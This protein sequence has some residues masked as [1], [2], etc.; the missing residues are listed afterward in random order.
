[1]NEHFVTSN[2]SIE[3]TSTTRS[4]SFDIIESLMRKAESSGVSTTSA[5]RALEG[6]IDGNCIDDAEIVQIATV[7]FSGWQVGHADK[8]PFG[9][10]LASLLDHFETNEHCMQV[11]GEAGKA[12]KVDLACIILG[13][14]ASRAPWA[15]KSRLNACLLSDSFERLQPT[16]ICGNGDPVRLW[17]KY[18]VNALSLCETVPESLLIWAAEN[19]DN[20]RSATC[21]LSQMRGKTQGWPW[22]D[23]QV[24]RRLPQFT[25][26]VMREVIAKRPED[27]AAC[28]ALASALED[29]GRYHDARTAIR[30]F[31]ED[32]RLNPEDECHL[33]HEAIQ[34]FRRE[35]S[36]LKQ[37]DGAFGGTVARIE[38]AFRSDCEELVALAADCEL[39][40]DSYLKTYAL[41]E[42]DHG[43]AEHALALVG[44]IESK[45]KAQL[46]EGMIR[47]DWALLREESPLYNSERAIDCYVG[48]WGALLDEKPEATASMRLSVLYPLAGALHD[49]QYDEDAIEVC[50]YGLSLKHEAKLVKLLSRMGVKAHVRVG[51]DVE[52]PQILMKAAE[53]AEPVVGVDQLQGGSASSAEIDG[54]DHA[55]RT[56]KAKPTGFLKALGILKRAS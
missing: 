25:E 52:F 43:N 50:E 23:R 18:F 44:Q 14:E 30:S 3:R 19:D 35:L 46:V 15:E 26:Q 48:A 1:M 51:D 34:V 45:Y 56:P 5:Q 38:K 9:I 42:K 21:A 55:D 29:Q 37:M 49:A 33:R 13:S 2:A 41:F 12:Y 32:A 36:S 28:Y 39:A 11:V 4:T 47:N 8:V 16:S 24:R 20:A 31:V 7:L 54:Q 27:V 40:K 6:L 22:Q 17:T 53:A 10:S